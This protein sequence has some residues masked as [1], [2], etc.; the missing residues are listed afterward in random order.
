ML[1]PISHR[2]LSVV[3]VGLI[4]V[5][6]TGGRGAAA[7]SGRGFEFIRFVPDSATL[8]E[9]CDLLELDAPERAI[10]HEAYKDV[11]QALAEL[12]KT[13]EARMERAGRS[14][15][16]ALKAELEPAAHADPRTTPRAE[17]ARLREIELS[18]VDDPRWDELDELT[19]RYKKPYYAGRQQAYAVLMTSLDSLRERLGIEPEDF[20]PALRLMRRRLLEPAGARSDLQDF[21]RRVDLLAL[22][23]AASDP[24][25][26]IGAM[27]QLDAGRDGCANFGERVDQFRLDYEIA[28][29]DHL[30]Q[31]LWDT[32]RARST[33]A[34]G[35]TATVD[36]FDWK[37]LKDVFLTPWSRRQRVVA[38]TAEAIENSLLE[39][40]DT[41]LAQRW[42]DRYYA[43]LCPELAKERWVHGMPDW[44]ARRDDAR[45]EQLTATA[46]LHEA[47]IRRFRQLL[48]RAVAAGLRVRSKQ[49]FAA[50]ASP[51]QLDYARTL[52]QMHDLSRSTIRQF[53]LLLDE[54]QASALD[55]VVH[56]RG[57]A[58]A[59]LL[60]PPIDGGTLSAL[61]KVE[62]YSQPVF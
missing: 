37:P 52:L 18:N 56:R 17:M 39:C 55:A 16:M 51:E 44:L 5:A 29:D 19:Q 40:G 36:E 50:G 3:A 49:V 4:V 15:A 45:P 38:Q 60:G 24:A 13:I 1:G 30:Q 33:S 57:K 7:A 48:D 6:S 23:D 20:A 41:S 31:V 22:I 43:A 8:D 28:L 59:T 35:Q 14:A 42:K 53:R 21:D 25:G 11:R 62:E 58:I 34:R 46:A 54:T 2:W 26:E 9:M 12:D 61:K 27:M 32:L 10:A 47:Y